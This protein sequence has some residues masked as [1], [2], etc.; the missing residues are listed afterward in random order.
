MRYHRL[1][2]KNEI[3][4]SITDKELMFMQSIKIDNDNSEAAVEQY[5]IDLNAVRTVQP[6]RTSF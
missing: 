6:G 3:I 2:M 4:I 5:L 1:N